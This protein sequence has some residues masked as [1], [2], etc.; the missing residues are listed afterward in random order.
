MVDWETI[1]NPVELKALIKVNWG[2][3][4]N[5]GNLGEVLKR[6][7]ALSKKTAGECWSEVSEMAKDVFSKTP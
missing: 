3:L 6:Y 5:E 2:K 4:V 1:T 7:Y